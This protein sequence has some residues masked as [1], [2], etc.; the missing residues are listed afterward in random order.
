MTLYALLVA[1][2]GEPT[3]TNIS[4]LQNQMGASYQGVE[5]DWELTS[6]SVQ[7]RGIDGRATEGYIAATT[8]AGTQ[9]HNDR[10][11]KHSDSL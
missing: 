2:Y 1:K 10:Q 11:P 5:A 3:Y 8:P 9:F 7:F 4:Q 6:M